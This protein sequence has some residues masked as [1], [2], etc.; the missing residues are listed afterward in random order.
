VIPD[1]KPKGDNEFCSGFVQSALPLG[2]PRRDT[3]RA[4]KHVNW[5]LTIE[6]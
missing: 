6:I 2:H 1:R 4:V 5:G 3:Q